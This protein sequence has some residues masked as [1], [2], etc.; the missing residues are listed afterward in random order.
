M[1]LRV[2][3]QTRAFD[4]A[5]QRIGIRSRRDQKSDQ[6]SRRLQG[7]VNPVRRGLVEKPEQWKGSSAA[8]S[9]S[10]GEVPI[11][12][13]A[14]PAERLDSSQAPVRS[15]AGGSLRSTTSHPI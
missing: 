10:A 14:S 9:L 15:A 4:G 12:A 5:A 2:H 13:D 3:A 11:R 6:G 8:W 1:G 7:D